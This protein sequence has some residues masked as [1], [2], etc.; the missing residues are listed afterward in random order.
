VALTAPLAEDVKL[1]RRALADRGWA[2]VERDA[3]EAWLL[4]GVL[5]L[6]AALADAHRRRHGAWPGPGQETAPARAATLLGALLDPREAEDWAVWLRSLPEAVL[7]DAGAFLS[8]LRRTPWHR[9]CCGEAGARERTASLIAGAAGAAPGELIDPALW[10]AWRRTMASI[11][12]RPDLE[13]GPPAVVLSTAAAPG[14]GPVESSVYVCFGPEPATVH[15]RV[16]SRAT[17]RLLVLYQEH[18]PLP[19]EAESPGD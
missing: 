14:A 10:Q 15:R 18:S 11:L 9:A 13:A 8:R 1:L 3:L 19:G 17:D 6:A 16:I 5:E 4:P 12:E 2:A 7:D